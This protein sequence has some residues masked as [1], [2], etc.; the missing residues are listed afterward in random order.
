LSTALLLSITALGA[1][2]RLMEVLSTDFPIGDGGLFYAMVEDLRAAGFRLPY[3]TSYNGA[4]I[5]FVY[6]P[7]ALYLTAGLCTLTG[8]MPEQVIHWLPALVSA[9]TI[10]AFAFLART[11]CESVYE[12]FWATLAFATLPRGF[13]YHVMGGG[14]TRAPGF[15][16]ALL[17]LALLSAGLR[18]G[19]DAAVWAAG[20]LAGLTVLTHP[21]QAW[22]TAYSSALLLLMSR[23]SWRAVA[24]YALIAG[25]MATVVSAPWWITVIVRHGLGM[26]LNAG[27]SSFSWFGHPY[28]FF[29][30]YVDQPFVSFVG[31][32]GFLGTLVCLSQRRWLPLL[33]LVVATLGPGRGFLSDWAVPLGL[34]AGVGCEQLILRGVALL[35]QETQRGAA[36]RATV[37]RLAAVLLFFYALAGAWLYLQVSDRLWSVPPEVRAAMDWSR[38]HTPGDSRFLLLTGASPWEDYIS[39][40][41]PALTGRVSLA[42]V[43]GYEWMPGRL[44]HKRSAEHKALQECLRQDSHCLQR[45]S[46]QTGQPFSYVFLV[47]RAQSCVPSALE[48]ALRA[49]PDYRLVYAGTEVLIFSRST[50][51]FGRKAPCGWNAPAR[52]I[53]IPFRAGG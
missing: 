4:D 53:G 7:L 24:R 32:T 15:V 9:L 31:L 21:D 3:V 5:P 46:E 10:P 11:L 2:L 39:E 19:K 34:L 18:R 42:T 20:M 8:W 37:V 41:F 44:F 45:W 13:H 1:Y 36:W 30:G 48:V 51:Q 29:F 6:P 49:A 16:L 26:F 38:D 47:R 35:A 28:I 12:W 50:R 43:Q 27:H 22:F 52:A 23:R 17:S 33:W 25:G 40:W 14:L